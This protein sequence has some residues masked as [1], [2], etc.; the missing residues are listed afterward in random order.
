M[1]SRDKS[2]NFVSVISMACKGGTGE[3]VIN[4]ERVFFEERERETGPLTNKRDIRASTPSGLVARASGTAIRLHPRDG[5]GYHVMV[6][7]GPIDREKRIPQ[8][9][10]KGR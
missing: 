10:K 3:D 6:A 1:Q 5:T 4:I 8:A 2:R 7:T 9:E